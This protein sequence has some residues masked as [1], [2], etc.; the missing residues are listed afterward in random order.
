MTTCKLVARDSAVV[1]GSRRVSMFGGDVMKRTVMPST[2]NHGVT[3]AIKAGRVSEATFVTRRACPS[4]P[5][6]P[7]A[8]KKVRVMPWL[9]ATILVQLIR[10]L[11]WRA[12]R[13]PDEPFR[14]LTI[15]LVA[16]KSRR[17]SLYVIF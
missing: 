5:A 14:A 12:R 11:S 2:R 3:E 4:I 10:W 9:C 17:I 6:R 8:Q 1:A 16:L 7:L 15:M 13:G